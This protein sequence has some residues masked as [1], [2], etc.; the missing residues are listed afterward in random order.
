MVRS[1]TRSNPAPQSDADDGW[2][3]GRGRQAPGVAVALEPSQ[4]ALVIITEENVAFVVARESAAAAHGMPV[5]GAAHDR[6]LA[7][8]EEL[9]AEVIKK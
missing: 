5:H 3:P 8:A 9:C 7:G 1:V 4:E 6:G 2:P